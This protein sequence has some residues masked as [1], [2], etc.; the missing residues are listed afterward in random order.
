M[1]DIED[2]STESPQRDR[3]CV[4]AMVL[5]IAAVVVPFAELILALPAVAFA[6][7]GLRRAKRLPGLYEGKG[8]AVAGLI[9]GLVGL[10][11]CVPS[12]LI[13]VALLS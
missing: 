9:L 12:I 11:M 6:I 1:E 7:A 8:M 13:L 5:G 3:L 4:T 10:V 2:T